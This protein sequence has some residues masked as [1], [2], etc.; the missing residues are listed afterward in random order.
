MSNLIIVDG[1]NVRRDMAGRY[2]LNDLHRA[3]GGEE[4]HKPPYWLSTAQTE[5]LIAELQICDSG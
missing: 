2:C 5:Q 4:R 1:I 3:A